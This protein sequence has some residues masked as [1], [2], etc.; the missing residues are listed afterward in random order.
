MSQLKKIKGNTFFLLKNYVWTLKI[1]ENIIIIIIIIMRER[2]RERE[3]SAQAK[4]SK[5]NDKK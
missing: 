2:G 4:V 1:I 5:T 3:R